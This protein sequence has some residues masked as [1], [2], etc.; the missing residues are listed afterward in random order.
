MTYFLVLCPSL[1]LSYFLTRFV[2]NLATVRGWVDR[3]R[4]DRHIHS[5]PIP[6][7]G[8]V[9]IFSSF[10]VVVGLSLIAVRVWPIA[11]TPSIGRVLAILVPAFLIFLLGLYD[12]LRAVSPYAKLAVQAIAAIVLYY[13]GLGI[14]RLD[15]VSTRHDLPPLVG[16]CLTAL[17]V[18]LI[19]NAFNL[20]DGLDGLAAGSALFSTLVVLILS[21]VIPNP[22][23]TYLAIALAGATLGFLPFNFQP[24][25]IFLGDCGSL[26][27]GFMLSALALEGSQKAPTMVAV[28]IP[29]VSFGLPI[30]DVLLAIFRRLLGYKP[31]FRGD[32]EHIHHKL[33]RRGFSQ[34][35]AVLILYAVTAA[36]GFLSLVLL[37]GGIA[38]ALALA[39]AAIGVIVGVRQLDYL[40]F[41][42]LTAM[43]HRFVYRRQML[44]NQ[45]AIRRAADSL[46]ECDEFRSICRV[47]R[48]TLEPIGFSGFRL[49]MAHPNGFS[50]SAFQPLSYDSDGV[51][52][53]FWSNVKL[54][55][56][57][58]ELQLE[59]V[60]SSNAKWGYFK[61]A[62]AHATAG[63]PLDV[64][65]LCEHFRKSLSN[66]L[67]RAC[68]QLVAAESKN[69]DGHASSIGSSEPRVSSTHSLSN[70]R[71][72]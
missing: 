8:G 67:D 72:L 69:G 42:E 47:L 45:L 52:D 60:T 6:R 12:D 70:R 37:H 7:L 43:F 71:I 34:Q 63:L 66:A 56:A 4:L 15:L 26:F 44:A 68:E 38:I 2:R 21:L 39:I 54:G 65:V 61:L 30:L 16:V 49:R 10:A 3:P 51:L 27:I 24:A 20:I 13:G 18:M 36:F 40:E 31:L 50:R 48:Q 22:T 25:S 59:L 46:D 35:D 55:E 64:N 53:Y 28:A 1:L 5:K 41:A 11:N 62:R 19:T 9:A 58:W 23:V 32:R 17:W 33:L 29:V 14:H 57:P